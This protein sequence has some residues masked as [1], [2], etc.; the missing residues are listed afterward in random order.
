M[1]NTMTYRGFTARVEYSAE[2]E[3]LVGHVLGV[4]AIIGFHGASVREARRDF[5]HAIDQYV[6][7]CEASGES[8]RLPFSG[9]M[10]LRL[11]PMLHARVA[12][13]AEQAGISANQWAARVL[14][15]A[16]LSRP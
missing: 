4:K 9:R 16:C 5:R 1:K 8:P 7:D 11:D 14:D 2:D 15:D 3:C 13:A 6:K 12:R 10:L